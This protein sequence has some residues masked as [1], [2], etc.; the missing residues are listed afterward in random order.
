MKKLLICLALFTASFASYSQDK[1]KL[2]ADE[3]TITDLKTSVKIDCSNEI[4]SKKII[5]Q[6]QDKLNGYNVK[7][8]K[9]RKG[10]YTEY[11]FYFKAEF[12]NEIVS[13]ISKY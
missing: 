4:I 2:I 1:N 10:N 3:T 11:S 5:A 6:F 12:K 8:K 9:D 7:F 13:T